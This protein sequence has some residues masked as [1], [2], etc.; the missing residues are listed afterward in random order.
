MRE[1][2]VTS[3]DCVHFLVYR[4]GSGV[5]ARTLA[6]DVSALRSY[7]RFLA[8]RGIRTDNPA[9]IIETPKASK[10]LP[11]VLT[12]EHMA[13]LLDS[14]EMDTPSGIRDRALFELIYSCGLRV[15]EA[16]S[17]AVSDI[18]FAEKIIMVR[19]KGNKE[20]MIPFGAEAEMYLKL[21]LQDAR[22]TLAGSK[23]VKAL[24]L[25]KRGTGIGRKGVWKRLQKGELASGVT[26]K[27]HTLRHSFATHLLAGGADLRSVQELMGH[28]DINTTQIYTHIDGETLSQFHSEFMDNYQAQAD[29]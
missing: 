24:F 5:S 2:S 11:T 26:S 21:Y 12:Q 6:K 8:L 10:R 19:G 29:I 22:K 17:L 18:N 13:D 1:A 23:P 14:F 4:S 16:T 15:S 9:E 25:N 7:F 20:R 27:V 3:R 28:A